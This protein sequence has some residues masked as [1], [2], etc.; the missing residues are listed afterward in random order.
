[1]YS[2]YVMAWTNDKLHNIH[3]KTNKIKQLK[4]NIYLNT[5]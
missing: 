5:S 1:M 4:I 3:K 2:A